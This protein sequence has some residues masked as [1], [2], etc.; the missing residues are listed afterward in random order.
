M[1]VTFF[2]RSALLGTGVLRWPPDNDP[3]DL[4]KVGADL[5]QIVGLMDVGNRWV[6]FGPDLDGVQ[7]VLLAIVT[8]LRGP[9]L[10]W[11]P[12]RQIGPRPT[13]AGEAVHLGTGQLFRLDAFGETSTGIGAMPTDQLPARATG[14]T[15]RAC[16]GPTT[17][18]SSCAP[19]DGARTR[20]RCPAS[21][22]VPEHNGAATSIGPAW[23]HPEPNQPAKKGRDS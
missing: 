22:P 7:V 19:S 2:R 15:E 1:A 21:A 6:H 5:A 17:T 8:V 13:Y 16:T 3:D 14:S 9:V 23:P 11:D 18:S 12:V 4:G 10:R 20:S